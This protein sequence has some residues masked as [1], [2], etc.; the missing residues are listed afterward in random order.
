MPMPYSLKNVIPGHC[1]LIF[2]YSLAFRLV[3]F[4]LCTEVWIIRSS[5]GCGIHRKVKN[6]RIHSHRS[7]NFFNTVSVLSQRVLKGR[8]LYEIS[9]N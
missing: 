5:S 2:P 7:L 6:I 4:P 9:L 3:H 8:K 1:S